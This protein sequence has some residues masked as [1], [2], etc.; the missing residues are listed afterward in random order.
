MYLGRNLN[1]RFDDASSIY[2]LLKLDEY[3]KRSLEPYGPEL[4]LIIINNKSKSLFVLHESLPHINLLYEAYPKMK[5]IHLSRHP[6]DVVH[7]WYK[8]NWG[9]RF[10][11]DPFSFIPV[12]QSNNDLVPWHAVDWKEEYVSLSSMDRI[13]KNISYLL[14]LEKNTYTSLTKNI[15]SLILEIKYEGI[16]ENTSDTIE[17]LS[18]F[19]G[20]APHD[21][22]DYILTREK[23]PKKISL[24]QRDNKLKEIKKVA[25]EKYINLLNKMIV[26]YEDN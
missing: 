25:S 10:Q 8:N 14:N 2:N 16:V 6:I 7:S 5:F 22:V 13:I 3:L 4:K 17:S 1:F 20:E 11:S 24:K 19:F 26:E 12:V 18:K 23:C 15:Q 9:S 21:Q